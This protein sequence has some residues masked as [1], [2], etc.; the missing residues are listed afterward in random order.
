MMTGT[1]IYNEDQQAGMCL[2]R[3]QDE[4]G[5][6]GV[7]GLGVLHVLHEDDYFA[8]HLFTIRLHC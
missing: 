7:L 2:H 8:V 4:M 1:V 3:M 5:L 6:G